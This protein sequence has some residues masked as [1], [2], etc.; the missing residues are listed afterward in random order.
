M[1][2]KILLLAALILTFLSCSDKQ[3]EKHVA[4]LEI[5]APPPP[6]VELQDMDADQKITEANDEAKPAA[7]TIPAPI[8]RVVADVSEKKIIKEGD[9]RFETSDVAKTRRQLLSSLKSLNGYVEDDSEITDGNQNEKE[10]VLSIRIPATNFDRFLGTV[11]NT[12]TKIDSR[13]IRIKD[14]TTQFIDTKARLDNKMKLEGRYLDLL[15]RATKMTDLLAI[16]DKLTEI[17]SDIESTQSQLN[18]LS[19][20][21]DFSSLT[22]TFYTRQAQQVASGN[23]FGYKLREALGSGWLFMQSLFFGIISLWPLIAGALLV[24]ILLKRW[25]KRRS[26][27]E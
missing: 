20:Q 12:A 13:N 17:R 5:V 16:E 25:R 9:I 21:V 6:A 8:N 7:S 1:K 23:G 27:Q 3:Q 26:H 14:V 22:I 24:Y 19:K 15:K 2:P 4:A 10:F 18:Y 11:S